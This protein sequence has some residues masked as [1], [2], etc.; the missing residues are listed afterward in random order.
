MNIRSTV[1][2]RTIKVNFQLSWSKSTKLI[3]TSI[4]STLRQFGAPIARMTTT[5]KSA[6]TRTTG[7]TSDG[8]RLLSSTPVKCAPIGKLTT[9][10]VRIPKVAKININA[11]ILTDGRS[12]NTILISSR[13]N[14]ASTVLIAKNHT[15]RTTIASM[16]GKCRSLRASATS[17]RRE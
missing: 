13:L 11:C 4:C 16:I 17:Q 3:W 14:N 7:K 1:P 10:L 12:K 8:V 2:L 15:V 9:S 6:S 5:V